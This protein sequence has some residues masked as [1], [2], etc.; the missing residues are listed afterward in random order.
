MA[1]RP[2]R[3]F[4][5][6]IRGFLIKIPMSTVMI[7]GSDDQRALLDNAALLTFEESGRVAQVDRASA[8]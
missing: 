4:R 2:T 5:S 1:L 3:E 6:E 7:V 8:F